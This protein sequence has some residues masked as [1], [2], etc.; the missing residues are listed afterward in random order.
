MRELGERNPNMS[1]NA[2]SIWFMSEK[3]V[4]ANDRHLL[5]ESQ[6]ESFRVCLSSIQRRASTHVTVCY[7]RYPAMRKR[8][9]TYYRRREIRDVL[10][11][12]RR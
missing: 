12:Y 6:R 9:P 11:I 2:H 3:P 4:N 8:R 10:G 7:R 1:R 5:N